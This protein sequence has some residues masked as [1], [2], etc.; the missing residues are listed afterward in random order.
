MDV[1]FDNVPDP[2]LQKDD[3]ILLK[4]TATAICGSYL[5]M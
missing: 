5:H 4:V 2:V 3:F 1:R